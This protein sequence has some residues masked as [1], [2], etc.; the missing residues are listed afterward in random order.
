[1][2]HWINRRHS[3]TTAGSRMARL[4]SSLHRSMAVSSRRPPGGAW[5]LDGQGPM[6]RAFVAWQPQRGSPTDGQASEELASNAIPPHA[7]N[8]EHKLHGNA[9]S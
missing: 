4:T 2:Q 6:F 3:I 8:L 1:M 5:A 9:S 7:L